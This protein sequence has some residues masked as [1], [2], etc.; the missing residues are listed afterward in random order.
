MLPLELVK[1]IKAL[2]G[3]RQLSHRQIATRLHVSQG[4]VSAI[5]K[6]RRGIYGKNEKNRYTPLAP[7][8]PAVRCAKCGNLVHPPCLICLA[9]ERRQRELTARL[10][11]RGIKQRREA[12]GGQCHLR[13]S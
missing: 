4:T 7:S 6:G 13:A 10:L 8:L 1:T 3:D 11:V 5:A 2:I 9:R 12:V